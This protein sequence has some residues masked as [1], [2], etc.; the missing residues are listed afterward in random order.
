MSNE[1][2]GPAVIYE[3]RDRK[4]YITLNR[5]HAMN[6]INSNSRESA[7]SSLNR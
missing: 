3:K 1:D 4:A 5:P 6:A 2:S 7:V